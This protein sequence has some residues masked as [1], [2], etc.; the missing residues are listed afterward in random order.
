MLLLNI[1]VISRI[2]IY[3]QVNIYYKSKQ[4]IYN[5]LYNFKTK[6]WEL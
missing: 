6:L 3:L 1:D 4:V 2:P 5:D